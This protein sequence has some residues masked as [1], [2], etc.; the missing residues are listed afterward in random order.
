MFL[1]RRQPFLYNDRLWLYSVQ[2]VLFY[3]VFLVRT[4]SLLTSPNFFRGN[5]MLSFPYYPVHWQ[6]NGQSIAYSNSNYIF[7]SGT[8]C[9]FLYI[10]QYTYQCISLRDSA[11][12]ISCSVS[13]LCMACHP[14]CFHFPLCEKA[15]KCYFVFV[16]CPSDGQ[17]TTKQ[18]HRVLQGRSSKNRLCVVLCRWQRWRKEAGRWST[19]AASSQILSIFTVLS[20]T[21][22]ETV[23]IISQF[24]TRT[25]IH[26]TTKRK[27]DSEYIFSTDMWNQWNEQI[28]KVSYDAHFSGWCRNLVSLLGDVFMG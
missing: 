12:F 24:M 8:Q 5:S 17:A 15:K 27:W 25:G 20:M 23:V 10:V 14:G 28:F 11:S 22:C 7:Y 26:G 3:V 16:V 21:N 9:A 1:L 6:V 2:N 4:A 13:V 18:R 19:E